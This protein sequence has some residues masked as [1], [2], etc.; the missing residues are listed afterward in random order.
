[1]SIKEHRHDRRIPC[2]LPIR[3]E[4]A[5][6]GRCYDLMD[7]SAGGMRLRTS[8]A[9]T[10]GKTVGVT[11]LLPTGQSVKG[12]AGVKWSRREGMADYDNG[13][14][15]VDITQTAKRRLAKHLSPGRLGL[16]E[17]FDLILQFAASL[18]LVLAANQFFV[19]NPAMM[20]SFLEYTPFAIV[21]GGLSVC[22]GALLYARSD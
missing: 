2:G 14:Q 7:A 22:L 6:E 4:G 18:T 11:I 16:T 13:L 20:E 10:V 21:I 3:V 5:T 1:M 19:S 9:M 17:S 15:F 12:C 8:S